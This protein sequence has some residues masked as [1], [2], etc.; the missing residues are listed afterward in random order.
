MINN[1]ESGKNQLVKLLRYRSFKGRETQLIINQTNNSKMKK[2]TQ[3]IN[4]K[5]E[6]FLTK[7]SL[8]KN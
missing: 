2:T 1:P 8:R 5:S 3:L 4:L 7:R 6:G